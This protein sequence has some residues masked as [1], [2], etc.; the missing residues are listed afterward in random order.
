[1]VAL[2]PRMHLMHEEFLSGLL[3]DDTEICLPPGLQLRVARVAKPLCRIASAYSM[4]HVLDWRPVD[5]VF[6]ETCFPRV[7]R[8]TPSD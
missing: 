4:L 6:A 7:E 5:D 1:M 3:K 8:K 2:A